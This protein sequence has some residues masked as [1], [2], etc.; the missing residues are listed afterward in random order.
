MDAAI[1]QRS[2]RMRSGRAAFVVM[3]QAADVR[4]LHDLPAGGGCTGRGMGASLS[5][6]RWVRN[7]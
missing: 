6:K 2:G 3:V 1:G 5:R 4:D 7:A